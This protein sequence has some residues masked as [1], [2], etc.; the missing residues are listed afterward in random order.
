MAPGMLG[1]LSN[2]EL[3]GGP[4][5]KGP[6]TETRTKAQ[7][8]HLRTDTPLDRYTETGSQLRG[9]CDGCGYQPDTPGKRALLGGIAAVRLACGQLCEVFP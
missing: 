6:T 8:S 5:L 9:F 2:A 7:E 4:K 3:Q 1:K